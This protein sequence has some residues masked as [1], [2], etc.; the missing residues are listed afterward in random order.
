MDLAVLIDLQSDTLLMEILGERGEIDDW[1]VAQMN[2]PDIQR[3]RERNKL[4]QEELKN[5]LFLT[6]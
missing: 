4:S 6:Y 5:V 1:T 3:E 2:R